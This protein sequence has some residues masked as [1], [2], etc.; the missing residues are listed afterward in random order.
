ME[1][2]DNNVYLSSEYSAV[3]GKWKTSVVEAARGPMLEVTN[4]R[5]HTITVMGCTQL[6]KSS[7]IT[8]ICGYFIHQDPCPI[9]VVQPDDNAVNMFSKERFDRYV[10][11]TPVLFERVSMKRR[12]DKEN[13][14]KNKFYPG[15]QLS[16]VSSGSP[17]ELAARPIR[18]VVFDEIDKYKVSAGKEGDPLSLAEE[19]SATFWNSLSVRVCSPTVEGNSRIAQEYERGDQ[20]T[21][22]GKCPHC[23]KYEDLQWSQVRYDA[24]DPD[25]F[26]A[27]ECS[28]CQSLWSEVD[29]Y[30]AISNGM[31][32]AKKPFKGHASFHFNVIASPWVTLASVVKK[33]L[34]AQ[35]NPMEEKVFVNT[36]LAETYKI[37]ADAPNYSRL[38]ERRELYDINTLD[39]RVKFLTCGVDVQAN[40]LELEIVGWG[41][42]KQSWSI[43]YRI[44]PGQTSTPEPW[45]KLT[46][47]LKETWR[48]PDGIL[49]NIKMLC[50]DSGYNTQH[51]Y[52]WV[53]KQDPNRV[54]AIKGSD[55]PTSIFT[56]PQ[57]VELN[58]N[59]KRVK[60]ALMLWTLGVNVLKGE[61]YSWLKMDKPS[62]ENELPGF[63]HFP[64]YDEEYFRGL[65]SE[66]LVEKRQGSRGELVWEK[67]YDRNEPLDVRGYARAAASMFG[68][69]RFTEDEWNYLEYYDGSETTNETNNANMEGENNQDNTDFWNNKRNNLWR[70][71]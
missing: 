67:V 53:R 36:Q 70:R 64:Q 7:L 27:Y 40:R 34:K 61:L 69:D 26:T 58:F 13:T 55:R 17:M 21:Y 29:R 45:D 35:G 9:L 54:R 50:V 4:P 24:K 31:S 38:Y 49:M 14:I 71:R 62:D 46:E 63:C 66:Q 1:W 16:I 5:C 2:A 51:V 43:D 10:R 6:L 57:P 39:P 18:I 65:C 11:D 56:K 23:N 12:G 60:N 52:N 68:L 20:R 47:L 42:D 48:H 25:K 32:I 19:R 30:K 8:N 41:K 15:G 59:G 33:Y 22:H 3:P 28:H 37:K 44:I